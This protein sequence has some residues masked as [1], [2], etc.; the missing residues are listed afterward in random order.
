MTHQS[1]L[2]AVFLG[3]GSSG[4][5]TA[6]TSGDDVIL[7]DCGFSAREIA[8]RLR[9]A[10]IDPSHVAA[11][12]VTHEHSDHIKGIDVFVR[13]HAPGCTVHSTSGTLRASGLDRTKI[14]LR[15]L[16]PGST[17]HVG[18]LGVVAFRT[19]HDAAE[20]VGYRVEASG[21]VMG[22]ATDTGV[23]THEA[24][25]ALSGADILGLE[26]NHDVHML[27]SGPYPAHLKRRIL[28]ARGHLSNEDAA[29]ALRRL[30]SDNLKQ[31]ITLHRST[32]NNTSALVA[33]AFRAEVARLGLKTPVHVAEQHRTH[34][35]TPPQT[36]LFG[37]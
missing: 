29:R 21:H 6:V 27:R 9:A 30:A 28:S 36:S 11:I 31:I 37:D 18:S 13:R 14:E 20:P 26:G 4:N 2:R 3:S 17:V 16:V 7:L 23:L 12:F 33:E 22:L 5:C 8:T 24:L 32:T 15:A 1:A 10:S 19:S 34:D 35:T 25:E